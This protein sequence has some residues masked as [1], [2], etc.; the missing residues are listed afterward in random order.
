[1]KTTFLNCR[2]ED[3]KEFRN[4]GR[5]HLKSRAEDFIFFMENGP[6]LESTTLNTGSEENQKEAERLYSEHGNF[7]EYGL[8]VD[9]VAPETFER[10]KEGY[11]RYQLSYGGP[12]E[13]VRFYYSPRAR[14]AYKIVFVYL[15]W[16]TGVGFDVTNENWAQWLFDWFNDCETVK[17]E[18]EKALSN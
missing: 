16:G 1:M 6:D 4:E 8:S 17:H 9:Y 13:E 10:Q 3:R 15:N 2:K 5:R 12:S 14:Q 18:E 7:Y 11:F